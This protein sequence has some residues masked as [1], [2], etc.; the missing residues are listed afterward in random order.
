MLVVF[1]KERRAQNMKF[2][3]FRFS[4]IYSER[5]GERRTSGVPEKSFFPRL[6]KEKRRRAPH[7]GLGGREFSTLYDEA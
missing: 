1:E 7:H 2:W 5:G 6:S 3:Q 4:R